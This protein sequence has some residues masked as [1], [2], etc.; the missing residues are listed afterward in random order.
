METILRR[1]HFLRMLSS[2]LIVLVL[3][4]GTYL[5]PAYAQDNVV[6]LSGRFSVIW[7][8]SQDGQSIMICTLTDKEG[9]QTLLQVS[10]TVANKLGGVLQFNRKDV[11]VKGTLGTASDNAGPSISTTRPRA[12]LKAISISLA[13]SP[14]SQA[15]TISDATALAVSGSHPWV[16][17]MCQFSDIAA[18]P[19]DRAY[20]LGMY[21]D[22]RPG[23]NH[24]WKELSFNTADVTGSTVAGTGWYT[25]NTRATYNP[26]YCGANN[27]AD[28][29][30]LFNACTAAADAAVDFSLYSGINLMFNADFDCGWAWGG[31]RYATLDGVTKTW[32]VTWEPPWGY[33][34]VSVISHEMGHGF[35]L[36]HSTA[37]G[38]GVYDNPWDVMSQDR[39][40]RAAATDPTYGCMAQHTISQY[41]DMLGWIPAQRKTTIAT[42]EIRTF[43]VEDLAVPASSNYQIV[44]IPVGGSS[45]NF[46]TLEARRFSGYDSKLPAEGV[47]IHKVGAGLTTLVPDSRNR[48]NPW[49]VGEIFYGAT[50]D[51]AATVTADTGTGFSVTTSS[52]I[53]K[54][55]SW[56]R[57]QQLANGSW[58]NQ[59]GYTAMATLA[60]L[61]AGYTES[62]ATVSKG[63]SYLLSSVQA[64]GGIYR[65]YGNY[66]TALS[67]LAL[68]ATENANYAGEIANA[69]TYIKSLQSDDSDDNA[70]SWYG[71]WGY[72]AYHKNTWSDLSNSQF[73]AMALDAAEV[74]KTDIVW[75]R[76]LRFLSR[77]QNID[78][79]NDMSWADGRTDGGFTYSP[80]YS[81]SVNYASYGSMTA[82]GIWGLRLSGVDVADARVQPALGW[83]LANEDLRFTSNPPLGNDRRYY[84]YMS[85]AKAMAMCF[86]SQDT[87]NAWYEGWY[88]SLRSKIAAE[89]EADGHWNR[90]Q[91]A[92]PDTLF[93][94]L[95]LQT[96]QP[97]PADLWMSII[98]AS[99]ADLIIYDP[100][101]RICSKDECTIPGA[102]FVIEGDQQIVNLHEVEPGHYR[103]VFAGTGDGPL[104]LTVNKYRG[105]EITSTVSKEFEISRH[106]VLE[107][108]VLVSSLIGAFTIYVGEPKLVLYYIAVDIK[109]SSCPN[110]VKV[111][112]SGVLP[113]AIMG[114]VYFNVDQID[115]ASIR[116]TRDGIAAEVPVMRWSYSDAGSPFVGTLCNCQGL[117]LDGIVDLALKFDIAAVVGTLKLAD[118]AGQTLPLT[119]T[120]KLKPE[121][122]GTPITGKDCVRVL[123]K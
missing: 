32:S 80:H 34:D 105:D 62:D 9:Q 116:L 16:T 115:P 6:E 28:L 15:P 58:Q 113:I 122:G 11:I 57:Q 46:Y 88:D 69:A 81:Y 36:P 8:D 90:A 111:K 68:K 60:F 35:G 38:D 49:N 119:V 1:H 31:V 93:A 82:A 56:L 97:L 89:Q 79:I 64:D 87:A 101:G 3:L 20:F 84:Y 25:I 114:E 47:I 77:V 52:P 108:D 65:A 92:Y 104:H 22:T 39:Y 120:G 40:N 21:S 55:L 112:E 61:N 121:Y 23:L 48:E 106:E 118:V 19:H 13:P 99:P 103:F 85:F 91:G 66:E 75:T 98:L 67:I 78:S 7:G 29:T 83:L 41:K 44:K 71:G 72:A 53:A 26:D 10:E 117:I 100:Q 107:S 51:I 110:P 96:Q 12:V 73:S 37:Y 86:L 5:T 59:V 17:I 54:G 76:F 42:G 14:E 102:E 18:Q 74:P 24:Y 50:N 33:A 123:R 2:A 94:L 70:H 95:A 43:V 27:G 30:A 4:L 109:P 45:T 63:I